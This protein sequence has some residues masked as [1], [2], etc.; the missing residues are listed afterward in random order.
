MRYVMAPSQPIVTSITMSFKRVMRIDVF[1]PDL[2]SYQ[3]PPE[4]CEKEEDTAHE[5]QHRASERNSAVK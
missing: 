1:D 4:A 2:F 5:S 3:N